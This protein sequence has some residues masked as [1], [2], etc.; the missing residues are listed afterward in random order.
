M[1]LNFEFI[2][3]SKFIIRMVGERVEKIKAEKAKK[4]AA[5]KKPRAKKAKPSPEEVIKQLE[6]ERTE[7]ANVLSELETEYASSKS[8]MQFKRINECIANAIE[9]LKEDLFDIVENIKGLKEQLNAP[10]VLHVE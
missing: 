10:I 1:R 9:E 2:K 7:M 5:P 8:M 4:P 3:Y 6:A